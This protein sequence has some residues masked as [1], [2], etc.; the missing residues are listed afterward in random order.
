MKFHPP[1]QSAILI[2][3]YKR[4]L[5]DVQLDNGEIITLH[6]PNT[7]SMKN[8]AEP[9]SRVWFSTSAQK[10]RKYPHTWEL[11][12]INKN[13]IGINTHSANKLVKEALEKK[14]ITELAEYDEIRS[15]VTIV[16][17]KNIGEKTRI[18]FQLIAQ[19]K[20]LCWVEV[21][22]VTLGVGQ[23]LGLFPDAKTE[24]GVKHLEQLT[25]RVQ[26]GE[27]AVLLFCVQHSGI[28]VVAPADEIDPLYGKRLREAAAAGVEILAYG[29]ELSAEEIILTK[30][31]KVDL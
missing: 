22:S 11:I 1:L 20:P 27:R 8:C 29:A 28:Q 4:F 3:R 2:Q 17:E 16:D 12:E 24:R 30:R 10:T 14:I 15:E 7:G 9:G 23:G 6:C 31:L 5:A 21:K 13:L 26:Q 19:D 25:A 18:D